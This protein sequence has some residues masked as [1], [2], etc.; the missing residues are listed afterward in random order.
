MQAGAPRGRHGGLLP[1]VP[2]PITQQPLLAFNLYIPTCLFAGQ[3]LRWAYRESRI[4]LAFRGPGGIHGG[5]LP[6]IPVPGNDLLW[7]LCMHLPSGTG[8]TNST[9]R[10]SAR[11][12]VHTCIVMQANNQ[13][14]R[15]V[16]L[17]LGA[18]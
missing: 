4:R 12:V 8:A 3:S 10:A 17:R 11:V 16:L 2:G 7:V 5:P 14:Y 1:C 9:G 15:M 18:Q 6:C 13:A